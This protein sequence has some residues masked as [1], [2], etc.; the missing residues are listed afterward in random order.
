MKLNVNTALVVVMT[1]IVAVI[2]GYWFGASG[3]ATDDSSGDTNVQTKTVETA[4]DQKTSMPHT[5]TALRPGPSEMP[6]GHPPMGAAQPANAAPTITPSPPQSGRAHTEQIDPGAKF[7]H[8][9]VGQRN[10]KRILADGDH[11]W[12]GTSGGVVRYDTRSDEYRLFDLRSGLLANGVFYLGKLNEQ[13]VA[14]TYGGGMALFDDSTEKWKIYNVPQGLADAF[15][16]DV[17][18]L[19]NGD[20]WV[21][22]WSGANRI[23]AGKLDDRSS[24][25]TFTVANTNNGLPNDW[26]YGL[27]KGRNNTVWLATEGGLSRYSDGQW[28]NWQHEHGLGAPYEVVRNDIQFKNDPAQFSKHHARQKNEMG[29]QGVDVAYNPNY[30]VA[31]LVARDGSVWCGTWGGGLSRFDG[32]TWTTYTVKDGLPGNHVFALHMDPEGRLLVGTSNGLARKEGAGFRTFTTAD[33]LFSNLV[34]SIA[35]GND[36]STWVGSF[37][38]VARVASLR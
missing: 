16:Y 35:T 30:I 13:I 6:A 33:G 29:L 15:V 31:L 10:V 4:G 27:A 19:D 32:E 34:F 22:T 38:G 12:V 17:L 8:F 36:G 18:Q 14:G 5:I 26:V 37:G 28:R 9:R 20:I 11:M 21:A 24:W 25:D 23:R 7:T 3:S 2:A 1:A